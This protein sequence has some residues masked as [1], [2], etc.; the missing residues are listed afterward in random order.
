LALLCLT[1]ANHKGKPFEVEVQKGLLVSGAV[2]SDHLKSFS[3]VVIVAAAASKK[4]V[5]VFL[6]GST[7]RTRWM[8]I[9]AFPKPSLTATLQ[10][11]DHGNKVRQAF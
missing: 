8:K 3:G 4:V 7:A 11:Q 5:A 9:D 10:M 1:T 6:M 2:L